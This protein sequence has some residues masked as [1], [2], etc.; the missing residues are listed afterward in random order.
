MKAIYLIVLLFVWP[1]F[2]KA[3][4]VIVKEET[5]RVEGQEV[6]GIS[7]TL[8]VNDAREVQKLWMNQFKSYGRV[9][10]RDGM[11][12]VNEATIPKISMNSPARTFSRI[13][14]TE[15]GTQVW[16]GIEFGE[17][18]VGP[19][20]H[21]SKMA[22]AKEALHQFGVDVYVN[23]VNKEISDAE[24]AIQVE[25]KNYESLVKSGENFSE[26]FE[27]NHL[28]KLKLEERLVQNRID[29][30]NI[31]NL[32]GQNKIDQTESLE[33]I[34]KLKQAKE[35]IKAKLERIK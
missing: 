27:K 11:F 22:A 14:L 15:G 7:A 2:T 23:E 25:V 29:S 35:L 19:D 9:N 26:E 5:A 28:Q 6:P 18:F 10:E 8:E 16:W 1:L 31:S 21:P 3:Q 34:E 33:E 32:I 13:L 17:A 4:T 24:R 30:V 20:H 12:V